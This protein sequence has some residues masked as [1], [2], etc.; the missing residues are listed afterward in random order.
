MSVEVN[1]TEGAQGP[2]SIDSDYDEY[3]AIPDGVHHNVAFLND[4]KHDKDDAG[5]FSVVFILS[6]YF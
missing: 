4:E 5:K 1:T 3:L 2:A 6:C